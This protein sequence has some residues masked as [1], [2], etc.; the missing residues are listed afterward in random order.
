MKTNYIFIFLLLPLLSVAQSFR[1]T[2]LTGNFTDFQLAETYNT[3][4]AGVD[5]SYAISY[6]EVAVY[7]GVYRFNAGFGAQDAFTI[8]IDTDPDQGD[9][10]G[11]STG[12]DFNG[13][14]PNLPFNA[15][16]AIRIEQGYEELREYDDTNG[17]WFTQANLKQDFLPDQGP[18][19]RSLSILKSDLGNPEMIRVVMW[20]GYAGGNYAGVPANVLASST[21]TFTEYFG[22]VAIHR[23]GSNPLKVTNDN[24]LVLNNA[25]VTSGAVTSGTYHRL[26]ISGSCTVSGDI[27]I[28]AGGNLVID[29]GATLDMGAH[30]L[31]FENWAGIESLVTTGAT[32]TGTGV[33]TTTN[34]G[35][36]KANDSS[37]PAMLTIDMPMQASDSFYTPGFSLSSS[38][39][40][41]VNALNFH[42]SSIEL[43][44]TAQSSGVIGTLTAG[45]DFSN[46]T[47]AAHKYIPKR[48]DDN[49]AF[50]FLASPVNGPTIFESIQA[51]GGNITGEGTQVTGGT[52]ANGFDQSGTNNPSMFTYNNTGEVWEA[53][54]NTNATNFE[55][56]KPFRTFIRGDRSVSLTQANQPATN[57]TLSA[58]GTIAQG[59]ITYDAASTVNPLND[60]ASAYNMIANPFPSYTDMSQVLD[61]STDVNPNFYYIWDPTVN[62]RGSYVTVSLSTSSP[63]INGTNNVVSSDADQ[64]LE[65]W[66]SCFIIND[67]SATDVSVV[68]KEAHKTTETSASTTFNTPA[69]LNRIAL[70]LYNDQNI[71]LDGMLVD[72]DPTFSNTIDALDALKIGNLDENLGAQVAGNTYSILRNEMP[73]DAEVLNLHLNNYRGA[74]YNL[75]MQR[76]GL[77]VY[78]ITLVDTYLNVQHDLNTADYSFPVD[79][80]I[81]GSIASDRFYLLFNNVS[82]SSDDSAF[83]KA[84]SLYP[85][86]VLNGQL[87]IKN[88]TSKKLDAAV[89]NMLGQLII[90]K[91]E[92]RDRLDL[93]KLQSGAY[94]VKLSNGVESLSTQVMV[95]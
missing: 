82:L 88:T 69:A 62:T 27:T 74:N 45:S 76:D 49:M 35:I 95:N 36:S 56:G 34:T 90:Q 32:I 13:V 19:H 8:F 4:Q 9:V 3:P 44:S 60:V 11:S 68:F 89:Y 67:D 71:A 43:L 12:N 42:N 64:F 73:Q 50:R 21:P 72:Y 78:D 75:S 14:T 37:S 7:I 17:T 28:A 54:T 1:P 29:D 40:A 85:N 55:V 24:T 63:G 83:A 70:T 93:S 59:D 5:V 84:I 66:Q 47:V 77:A 81:A 51:N 80:S 18:G 57:T 38:L 10:H 25:A 22:P 87:F 94:I 53:V 61:Q 31:T 2:N 58:T 46:A 39:S 33:L 26:Q 6:D 65:P 41:P 79:S 91:K 15:D 23:A 86:P 92:I 20:M 48:S 30:N 52:I 16:F